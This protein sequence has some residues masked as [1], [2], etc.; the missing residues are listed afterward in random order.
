MSDIAG[1]VRKV[2]LN[3]V[4]FDVMS[5][6]NVSEMGSSTENE[7]LPTSG[8]NV[9]KKTKRVTTREG[10]VL[11]CNGAEREVLV[12][13]ADATEDFP[14]S[15]TTAGG[16]TYRAEGAIEFETR[17]TEENRATIKMLPRTDWS[18]FVA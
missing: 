9:L 16:D 17:E 12:A 2:I 18:A 8:R 1:T 13:L 5:D 15:Y 6:T 11:A 4:S 7:M 10:V 3:G 14:M